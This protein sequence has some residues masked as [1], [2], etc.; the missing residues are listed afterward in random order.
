LG[1]ILSEYMRVIE[2]FF[3][4]W[5]NQSDKLYI[6]DFTIIKFSELK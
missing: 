2:N 5:V 3:I 4:M 1:V 6:D